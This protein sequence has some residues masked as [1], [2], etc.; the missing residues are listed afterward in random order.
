MLLCK[1]SRASLSCAQLA[2]FLISLL[3]LF[4][5]DDNSLSFVRS[6]TGIVPLELCN[7]D[8]GAEELLLND[9]KA[10]GVEALALNRMKS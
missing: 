3:V 5:M 10:R 4:S 8:V 1:P 6:G 9:I 2:L 7:N